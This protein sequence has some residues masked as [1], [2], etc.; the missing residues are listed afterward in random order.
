ML[1]HFNGRRIVPPPLRNDEYAFTGEQTYYEGHGFSRAIKAIRPRR[2]QPLGYAFRSPRF[3]IRNNSDTV[4]A[5][6]LNQGKP[7]LRG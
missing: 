2:L 4:A 5:F 1:F 7:Y 3:G 6:A